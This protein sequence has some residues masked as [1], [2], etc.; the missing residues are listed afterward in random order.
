MQKTI[1]AHLVNT[2]RMLQC[3]FPQGIDEQK[4]LPLLP[5]LYEQMSDR[6]LAQVVAEYTG[7]KYYSVL[8]DVYQ[9]GAM[10]AFPVELTDAIKRKL[11]HCGYEKWLAEG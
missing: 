4:Y 2:Y 7:R 3:A 8:N 6:G 5:V 11:I 1:P 9:V 10:T